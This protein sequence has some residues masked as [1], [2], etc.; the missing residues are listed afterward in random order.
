M[1]EQVTLIEAQTHL[2]DLINAA[3]KGKTVL[4]AKNKRQLVQLVPVMHTAKR[5]HFGSAKGLITMADDFDAPL[6]DLN[7][8]MA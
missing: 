2:T 6:A 1:M 8:Y 7:E 3:F 5:R 4:I